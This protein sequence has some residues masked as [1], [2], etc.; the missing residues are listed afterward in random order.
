MNENGKAENIERMILLLWCS[1][2][3]NTYVQE[4]YSEWRSKKETGYTS[5]KPSIPRSDRTHSMTMH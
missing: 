2:K 4:Q 5:G 3:G 1:K